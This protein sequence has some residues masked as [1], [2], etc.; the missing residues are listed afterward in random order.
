MACRSSTTTL[1]RYDSGLFHV[2]YEKERAEQ[3]DEL[4]PDL[5][6]DDRVLKDIITR[7]HYPECPCEF[8]V[9]PVEILGHVYEQFPVWQR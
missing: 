1:E 9:L 4:T 8:S 3:P 6:I 7:L 2:Q 5:T